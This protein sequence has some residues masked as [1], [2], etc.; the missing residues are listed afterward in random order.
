MLL[1]GAQADEHAQSNGGAGDGGNDRA[2]A[3]QLAGQHAE[4]A[5]AAECGDQN[6]GALVEHLA[7]HIR[8][9]GEAETANPGAGYAHHEH[10]HNAAGD[11]VPKSSNTEG[12]GCAGHTHNVAAA[13][14]GQSLRGCNGDCRKAS[15]GGCKVISSGS[16]AP[17]QYKRNTANDDNL[18]DDSQH[19]YT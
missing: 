16:A 12:G 17:I 6:A 4:A 8:D 7:E 11:L 1:G 18:E 15:A 5:G 19:Q 3:L 13:E 10:D 14:A 9:V 2:Y